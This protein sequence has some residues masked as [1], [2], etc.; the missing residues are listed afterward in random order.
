MK[1]PRMPLNE[2]C[3]CPSGSHVRRFLPVPETDE[4][5]DLINAYD[6][7]YTWADEVDLAEAIERFMRDGAAAENLV[8]ARGFEDRSLDRIG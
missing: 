6:N 2:Y 8:W 4:E 3:A 5:R 1:P 7:A